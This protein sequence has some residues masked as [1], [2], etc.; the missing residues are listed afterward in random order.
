MILTMRAFA[1]AATSTTTGGA[2]FH[3]ATEGQ[4][5]R[6]SFSNGCTTDRSLVASVSMKHA[7]MASDLVRFFSASFTIYGD[8]AHG[9]MCSSQ[10]ASPITSMC[11]SIGNLKR[12]RSRIG[13]ACSA[14][15][16]SHDGCGAHIARTAH[17]IHYDLPPMQKSHGQEATR[18]Q[19]FPDN[20]FFAGNRTIRTPR[21]A[22]RGASVVLPTSWPGSFAAF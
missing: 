10:A 5:S 1:A 13:S 20:Y 14:E 6:P 22:M 19:T 15:R 9:W 18:L 2:S 17:Y 7:H 16:A 4:S 12:S 8:I 11:M 21:S 3:E